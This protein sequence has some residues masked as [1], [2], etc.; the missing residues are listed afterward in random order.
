MFIIWVAAQKTFALSRVEGLKGS[1]FSA[2]DV[3]FLE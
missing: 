2:I 1:G 3:W